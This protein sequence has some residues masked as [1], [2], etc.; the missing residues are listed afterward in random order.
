MKTNNSYFRWMAAV[1]LLVISTC[2]F[3]KSYP[4]YICNIQVTDGNREQLSTQLKQLGFLKSGTI[5]FDGDKTL[6]LNN[7]VMEYAEKG[8][9]RFLS[10]GKMSDFEGIRVEGGI[11]D[12]VVKVVGTNKVTVTA[13][14]DVMGDVPYAMSMAITMVADNYFFEGTGSLTVNA[15]CEDNT[16]EYAV[17][18]AL[19]ELGNCIFKGGTY[20][21]NGKTSGLT[22]SDKVFFVSGDITFTSDD[23]AAVMTDGE[24]IIL[25]PFMKWVNPENPTFNDGV[26]CNASGVPAKTVKIGPSEGIDL[27]VGGKRVTASNF[28]DIL[29]DGGRVYYDYVYNKLTLDG[30]TISTYEAGI[31]ASEM[32]GMTIEMKG[33][34][35]IGGYGSDKCPNIWLGMNT[36]I[37]GEDNA[38]LSVRVRDGISFIDNLTINHVNMDVHGA[39]HAFSGS[40]KYFDTAELAVEC[41]TTID[42]YNEYEDEA[43]MNKLVVQGDEVSTVLLPAYAE[44]QP[45]LLQYYGGRHVV[46]GD[47]GK[48]YNV[49][50]CGW[51]ICQGNKSY[52]EEGLATQDFLKN[53]SIGFNETTN[54]LILNGVTIESGMDVPVISARCYLS[55][56]SEQVLNVELKGANVINS[57]RTSG[58]SIDSEATALLGNIILSTFFKGSGSLT[59]NAGY[60]LFSGEMAGIEVKGSGPVSFAGG[61]YNLKGL[62]FGVKTEGPLKINGASMRAEGD[63]YAVAFGSL[64]LD[65]AA[66][67]TPQEYTINDHSIYKSIADKYGSDAKTVVVDKV[68]PAISTAVKGAEAMQSEEGQTIHEWHTLDGRLVNQSFGRMEKGIYI[69]KGRKV[70]VK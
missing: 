40:T 11:E 51:T 62:G 21:F 30:A 38:K 10:N 32:K 36:T 2:A 43:V 64:Q 60:N 69:V 52:L 8:I 6:E 55:G 24:D 42:A 5:T 31:D 29:N 23:Y 44:S 15:R 67:T 61:T 47:P 54:T 50:I 33:N 25:S 28:N 13:Q 18:Y 12:L 14:T 70:V 41:Y 26:V 66:I 57:G 7:V 46:V 45:D 59:V 35:V 56:N 58:I 27:Y 53:G 20:N 63:N 19:M 17:G 34:N 49:S 16:L 68:S 48:Y 9:A 3:A 1:V 39:H 65:N 37:I 4:L 22:V